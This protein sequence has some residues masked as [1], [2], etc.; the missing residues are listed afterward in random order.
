MNESNL[1]DKKTFERRISRALI[2]FLYTLIIGYLSIPISGAKVQRSFDQ[3][4][5]FNR[6]F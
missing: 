4:K 1:N 3:L 6:K 5:R 2:I